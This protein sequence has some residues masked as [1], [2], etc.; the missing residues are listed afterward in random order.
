MKKNTT[1]KARLS[2]RK[3]R[4]INQ[5]KGLTSQAG[6]IPV[7]RFLDRM[8]F[9][10]LVDENV[11]HQRGDNAV[12]TLTD[13]VLLTMVGIIGGAGSLLKVVSVWSDS[14]LRRVGGWAR[15]PDDS[16]LGRLFKEVGPEHIAQ[17]EAFNHRLRGRVWKRALR[18]GRSTLRAR[19]TLWVDVDST[20]KTVFGKPEGAA[21]GYNPGRRG[22]LSYHPLLAFC[23][24]SKEILQAWLRAGSAYTGNGVVEFMKQL[25]A[26]LPNKVRI[27]FRGDK[28]FFAGE[29]L[30]LLDSR[31][32]GYL[33]KVKLKNLAAVL[34]TQTWSAISRQEGWEQCEFSYA[35]QNWGRPR[36]FVAV[37]TE[38]VSEK[39]SAQMELLPL[40]DYEYF[41]YVCTE[42]FSPWEVHK[43]Y[44][45]R[46]TCE[47]WIDEA[48]N[49]MGLGQI[50]TGE[51][52]AN[53]ALFQCAVLAYNT[54][55]WVALLSGNAMLQRWEIQTVRAFL[56]RVAGKLLTASRQ[57]V[58]N[59]PR[60][61]LFQEAWDDWVAVGLLG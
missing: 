3:V 46:A 7:V 33:I 16:T 2:S 13:A 9:C 60:K 25:L 57:L 56:V 49:Q 14:V 1:S 61:H 28:G 32:H 48:K 11:G 42:A 30:N 36:R 15:I 43:K 17:L 10:G 34:E 18:E 8:G 21:K 5:A 24:E 44:G 22:A 37:R 19:Q 45:E 35:C 38:Q 23:V 20:V 50:K 53:S 12:Y 26:H 39:K 6:L 52:L 27:V 4:I 31:G 29:L 41:C 40:K 55:R 59:T 51:F 58:I 54:V 47:T